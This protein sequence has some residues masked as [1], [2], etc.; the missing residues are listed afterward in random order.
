MQGYLPVKMLADA[1]RGQTSV[2]LSKGG[3]LDAGTEIV[4]AD[5]VQEP[6]DLPALTF[7]DLEELAASPEKA[8]AYYEPL[9]TNQIASWPTL[10]E[11][12]EN[13]AK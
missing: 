13:E 7:A 10:L 8:R 9:V 12:I 4:T 1:I 3:F 11:P 6:Y 5:E 2:D